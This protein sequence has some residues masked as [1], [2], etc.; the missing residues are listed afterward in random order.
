MTRMLYIAAILVA[1]AAP[2][3]LLAERVRGIELHS[4]GLKIVGWVPYSTAKVQAIPPIR[5][6]NGER[7]LDFPATIFNTPRDGKAHDFTLSIAADPKID[8][9]NLRLIAR[10]AKNMTVRDFTFS[11]V[12]TPG[13][14]TQLITFVCSATGDA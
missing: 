12:S 3:H 7:A 11:V 13:L 10:D 9:T 5:L 4:N 6:P 1:F 8:H 2:G 14:K